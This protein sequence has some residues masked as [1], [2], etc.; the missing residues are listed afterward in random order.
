MHIILSPSHGNSKPKRLERN[1]KERRE[2]GV[3]DHS[4]V[5]FFFE[6][7]PR[8]L[9]KGIW[10]QRCGSNTEVKGDEVFGRKF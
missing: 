8:L 10:G 9:A 5:S 6:P 2:T 1:A 4:V 7:T 3:P